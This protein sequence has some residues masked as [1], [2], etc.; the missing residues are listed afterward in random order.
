ML[1]V[2]VEFKNRAMVQ[3]TRVKDMRAIGSHHQPAGTWS[4]DSSLFLC[5]VNGMIRH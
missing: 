3:A 4:D 5:T 2:P 1:G